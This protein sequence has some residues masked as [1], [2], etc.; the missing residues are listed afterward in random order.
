MP[1]LPAPLCRW[2]GYE[3]VL[4][5]EQQADG[6]VLIYRGGV[7]KT[8]PP[9]AAARLTEEPQPVS[10]QRR[11]DRPPHVIAQEQAKTAA[12]EARGRE[13]LIWQVVADEQ[14]PGL[15]EAS[16]RVG[17]EV[18]ARA[19]QRLAL[20]QAD[21]ERRQAQGLP[22]RQRQRRTIAEIEAERSA[23]AARAIA[24]QGKAERTA[25][26]EQR[27]R[28]LATADQT[29]GRVRRPRPQLRRPVDRAI[30]QMLAEL[31]QGR[32]SGSAAGPAAPAQSPQP[33]GAA[34]SAPAA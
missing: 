31:W 10:G 17:A 20:L 22:P 32:R 16:R 8:L 12:R 4:V 7:L 18:P 29:L 19:L 30:D 21:A 6:S 11:P 9:A 3:P 5:V 24:G 13:H 28:H 34:Q 27:R 25:A 15:V 2:L 23:A 26:L 33:P 1:P 14:L